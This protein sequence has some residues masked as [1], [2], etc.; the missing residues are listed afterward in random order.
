MKDKKRFEEKAPEVKEKNLEN[1]KI[2]MM[3]KMI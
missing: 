1:I 2:Q 3:R